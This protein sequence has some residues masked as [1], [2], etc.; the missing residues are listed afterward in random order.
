MK[1]GWRW[2]EKMGCQSERTLFSNVS[3][4]QARLSV[5]NACCGVAQLTGANLASTH[6]QGPHARGCML[7]ACACMAGQDTCR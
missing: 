2:R 6:S 1:V 7:V 5:S 3:H 4:V